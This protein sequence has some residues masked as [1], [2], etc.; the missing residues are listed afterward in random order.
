MSDH[1]DEAAGQ[2]PARSWFY[3]APGEHVTLFWILLIHV[4]AVVG[5]FVLPL[6]SV[7]L[8][9]AVV[10]LTF[11]GGLGTTICYHR[12][13][14]HRSVRL[15]WVVENALILL[16]CFNGS[17]HPRAW[18]GNHRMHHAH[19]DKPGDPS[20]P[21]LGGFWWSHLF[22]LWQAERPDPKR[23]CRDLEARRYYNWPVLNIPVVGMSFLFGLIISPT[24]WLWL[25]PIRL[26]WALHGQCSINSVTHL[27]SLGHGRDG[28]Q[29][30]AWLT[31]VILGIGENWHSNHHAAPGLPRLGRRG[32]LDLGWT[33]IR[34]MQRLGLASVNLADDGRRQY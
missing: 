20:S 1:L 10:A 30:V 18:V 5:L 13:L 31:P 6:P 34:L 22:W 25:G 9:V 28:S 12:A 15:P 2:S 23:W 4:S 29:N 8:L 17:S 14:S 16:A 26:V 11:L 19:A 33:V 3:V 21:H 24:A 27:G 32:Q 7:P